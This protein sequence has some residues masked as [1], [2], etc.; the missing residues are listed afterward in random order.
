MSAT[1]LPP[2]GIPARA[3][4]QEPNYLTW[5]YSVKDWL[6]TIDHKRIA[7]LYLIS[8]SVMFMLGGFAAMMIRI[9][10]TSPHGQLLTS[11]VYNKMFTMHGVLMVFFFLVPS[12]PA[13]LGNFVIPLM[14]GAK[15]LAFPRLNLLSWYLYTIGGLC[16][17]GAMVMGGVDTGW[18]FYTPYSSVYSNSNVSLTLVGIFIAGF[19]SI[20]TGINF[21]VTIHKM[22]AP[23]LTWFRLPLFIW[24]HY[25]TSVVIIL[26]TPVV[27]ITLALVVVERLLHLGIFNPA[28]GGDP[29]LFQHMFW[30][31][32]HPAVYIMILP[33]MGIVSEII[34]CFS[35]KRV[36]G[37]SFV[38]FSSIAIGVFGFLVW[39]HHMFV[40]GQSMYT[41]MVFSALSFIVA[42]PSAIK[43]F[44]WTAT[45][46]KGQVWFTAPMLYALGFIGLFTV[47]GLTGLYLASLAM[48]VH[49]NMTYFVVAHFHFVMVG[50]ATLGYLGGLHFWWPKITGRMYPEGWAK[51]AAGISF[52]G[53]N[54]TFLPQFI[55]GYLGMPRRYHYYPAEYQIWHILSSAGASVLAV[56]YGIPLIY[57]LWSLKYGAKA[58]DNPWGA[59]GLEWM[60]TS[61][62][63]M[64]NFHE[65]PVVTWEAYDYDSET[66]EGAQAE[67]EEM[68]GAGAAVRQE[69]ARD[70]EEGLPQGHPAAD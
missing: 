50:G 24:A 46:Y 25:A 35:R 6:L 43:V 14:I 49:L 20:L 44:N 13:T 16:A 18:T 67:R 10:L 66:E 12:I 2:A 41:G 22:R 60:T 11:E 4:E 42:V 59:V 34:A 51:L 52:L 23:G 54:L 9:E 61:P 63:P 29:I 57:F 33:S 30:F 38:A 17:L 26:G 7:V 70:A 8:I 64:E 3:G 5:S 56:G 62:P 58:G 27:A 32:S 68:P 37:Y 36:F 45:I 55:V 53:F 1:A 15:D 21:I 40:T 31:Y 39:G 28:L 19:S 48:D 69:A 65:T 47:G